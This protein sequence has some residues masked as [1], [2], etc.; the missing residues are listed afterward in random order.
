MNSARIAL[1][2]EVRIPARGQ[3]SHGIPVAGAVIVQ[4]TPDFDFLLQ[5]VSLEETLLLT[6]QVPLVVCGSMW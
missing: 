4:V 3:A 5:T 1:F 6:A 2:T